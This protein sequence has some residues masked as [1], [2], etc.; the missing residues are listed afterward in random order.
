M[1][2]GDVTR[3]MLYPYSL[4]SL[5]SFSHTLYLKC[6]GEKNGRKRD[7]AKENWHGGKRKRR[8]DN[9]QGSA[10]KI[11]AML[12]SHPNHDH[13]KTTWLHIQDEISTV[14]RHIG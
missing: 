7:G 13:G 9:L 2:P 5:F 12:L 3:K 1:G 4:K 10:E 14:I 8:C 6:P 11:H